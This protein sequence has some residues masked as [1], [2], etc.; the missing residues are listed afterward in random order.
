MG[1]ELKTFIYLFFSRPLDQ[2]SHALLTE[3][4]RRPIQYN[5]I[6]IPMSFFT[7]LKKNPKM[8]IEPQDTL[9]SQSNL[10]KEQIWNHHTS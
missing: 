8:N 7:E 1:L 9:N 3:P 6:K 4:D 10:E 2:E 5:F